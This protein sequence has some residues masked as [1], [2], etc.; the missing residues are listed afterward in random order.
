MGGRYWAW[1]IA[2]L[3]VA[4]GLFAWAFSYVGGR[5]S[6][7]KEFQKTLDAMKQVRSFR[8][9]TVANPRSTQHSELLWEVDCQRDLLHFQWHL[10]DTSVAPAAEVDEDH[11]PL[12]AMKQLRSFRVATVANPR[13]TQHSELLWEV[14]CQ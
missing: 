7:E 3:A 12:H 2:R 5:G 10:R 9:A 1:L 8:V 13:S 11:K 4:V 14:D 6:G